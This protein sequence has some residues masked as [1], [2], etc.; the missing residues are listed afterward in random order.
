MMRSFVAAVGFVGV[1]LAGGMPAQA[2]YY[3][4]PPPP[5]PPGYYPPRGYEPVPFG[6]RCEAFL[7]SRY[8]SQ[9][10]VCRIVRAKPLGEECACPPPPP[11]P[12]YAPGPYVGGRTIP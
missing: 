7:Q 11:P 3:A 9:R 2:Q 5:P 12:G 4:E 10:V 1:L 6:R 8:G